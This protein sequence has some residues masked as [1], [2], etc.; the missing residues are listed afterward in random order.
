MTNQELCDKIDALYDAGEF[1]EIVSIVENLPEKEQTYHI[2]FVLAAAYSDLSDLGD[3]D[4]NTYHTTTSSS[5]N[6][7][8]F[9][10]NRFT[11]V[12]LSFASSFAI[13]L[14]MPLCKHLCDVWDLY[15]I[16]T[17]VSPVAIISIWFIKFKLSLSKLK[18]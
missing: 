10:F 8:P 9:V 17:F 4:F 16:I 1:E 2:L 5:A 12:T 6:I 14:I 3:D 15:S 18:L 11:I 13:A 7:V